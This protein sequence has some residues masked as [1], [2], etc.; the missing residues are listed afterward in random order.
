MLTTASAA[1][2]GG[3][4]M[5]HYAASKS[6]ALALHEGLYSELKHAWNAPR[7]RTTVVLPG[8]VRTKMFEGLESAS[9][10]FV[11]ALKPEDVAAEITNALKSGCS[12]HIEMPLMLKW[13]A[14]LSKVMPAWYR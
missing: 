12:R 1:Y 8:V 10:F 5:T 3:V 6:A 9:D 2:L 14:P 4:G 13:L 11:P 7:V